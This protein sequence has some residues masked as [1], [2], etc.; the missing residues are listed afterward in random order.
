MHLLNRPS[1]LSPLL[2][3]GFIKIIIIIAIVWNLFGLNFD[4]KKRKERKG[5]EMKGE[6]EE[7]TSFFSSCCVMDR[8]MG[9]R[10]L[11]PPLCID[12]V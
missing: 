6:E 1:P 7:R 9:I 11:Y 4:E 8:P 10:W 12:V 5:K 2:P 3:V